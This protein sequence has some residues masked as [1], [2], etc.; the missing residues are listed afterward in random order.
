MIHI[1]C[2]PYNNFYVQIA[3]VHYFKKKSKKMIRHANSESL[4]VFKGRSLDLS[5]LSRRT[6]RAFRK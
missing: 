6:C 3:L 4:A 2:P 5:K 1:Y